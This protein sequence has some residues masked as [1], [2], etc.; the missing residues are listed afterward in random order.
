MTIHTDEELNSILDAPLEKWRV[1]LHP[2]QER[3][4][5][6]PFNGPA[7][8]TGGAGT[9]KT[10]V[11]MHRA[12][13]LAKSLGPDSRDKILFTT[14][15]ANLADSVAQ[16][17]AHL[18][19]PEKDGIEVV[20]LHAWAARFLRD[21]G[22]RFE[23]ASPSEV[24]ACWEEAIHS[25]GER[26]FNVGFLRQE[27]EQVVRAN[28][29]EVAADYLKVPRI[30][31]GRTLS[32]LQRQ[33]VWKVCERYVEALL[34][35]G[36]TEWGTVV[37]DAR[38]LIALKKSVLPYKAVVVDEAQDF[39]AEDWRLL[40][41]LVPPGPNDLFL[42]GDAHQRIYGHKVT[43]RA[44][45]VNVQGARAACGSTT[46]PCVGEPYILPTKDLRQ[47]K[48]TISYALITI[49]EGHRNERSNRDC[50]DR[51]SCLSKKHVDYQGF[52]PCS[53]KIIKL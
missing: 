23:V 13:H 41:A 45:G 24:D 19:G 30:G 28:E 47:P 26:E 53:L 37:R 17:L 27:W 3:L 8:V 14:F 50:R 1:F 39:A 15:T 29:I 20:H 4:V 21:Q 40:R 46:Q 11:A 33:R 52:L 49:G 22:R 35:R 16:N 31:R 2:S 43:L 51:C 7:R 5:T 48:I 34:R 38:N 42:V 44:C 32:R 9:G 36:K 6:K 10:V 25:S 18:C 12:R